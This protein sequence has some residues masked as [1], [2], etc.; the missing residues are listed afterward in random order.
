MNRR[1]RF[2]RWLIVVGTA[3]I[4]PAFILKCDKAALNFQRGLLQG[5]GD[6]VAGLL[7]TQVVADGEET[8]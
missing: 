2:V 6:D 1:T 4:L 8:G 5:L 3:S 7:L